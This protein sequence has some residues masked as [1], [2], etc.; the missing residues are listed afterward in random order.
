[1]SFNLEV[2]RNN[3]NNLTAK[4]RADAKR[5][6]AY[7]STKCDYQSLMKKLTFAFLGHKKR[8]KNMFYRKSPTN[9]QMPA[10]CS[11]LTKL[12]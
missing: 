12:L 10:K 8:S 11:R 9:D 2:I 1:M 7:F 6:P 3:S 5:T 4:Y